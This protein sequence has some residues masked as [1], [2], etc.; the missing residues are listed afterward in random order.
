MTDDLLAECAA[1]NWILSYCFQS[2]DGGLWRVVLH[3]YLEEG[4]LCQQAEAPTFTLALES[5]MAAMAEAEFV[6]DSDEVTWSNAPT[7]SL[8]D[9]ING[10][11]EKVRRI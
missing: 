1:N 4:R 6:L 7:L 9:L 2:A 11:V 3:H 10:P 5:C 8:I